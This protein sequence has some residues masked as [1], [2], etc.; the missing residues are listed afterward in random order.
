MRRIGKAS[1][2]TLAMVASIVVSAVAHADDSGYSETINTTGDQSLV[3]KDD[4]L[5]AGGL[6]PKDARITVAPQPKRVMLLRARTQFVQEML[7]SV[8]AL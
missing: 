1:A 4:P 6:G 2:F 3:F 8:E 5:D 7:K